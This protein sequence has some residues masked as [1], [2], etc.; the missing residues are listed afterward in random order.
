MHKIRITGKIYADANQNDWLPALSIYVY[1]CKVNSNRRIYFSPKK[2]IHSIKDLSKKIG[3]GFTTLNQHI[4]TLKVKGLVTFESD[5]IAFKT[6]SQ[7]IGISDKVLFI[8]ETVKSYSDV[9]MF[10][11]AIPFI[12][13]LYQQK[14]TISKKKHLAYIQHKVTNNLWLSPA[15]FKQYK[16]WLSN[17]KCNSS[18]KVLNEKIY[19]TINKVCDLI[20][21]KSAT[22]AVKYKKFL[23]RVGVFSIKN[24]VTHIFD[25][26]SW[27]DYLNLKRFG[28]INLKFTFFK[29]GCVWKYNP[30]EY[31]IT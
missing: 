4:N 11:N 12:S 5:H 17:N 1:F 3:V 21:K 28:E 2:R 22:T 29:F 18:K 15:E 14:R 30:T 6:T 7:I 23:E 9:K 8:P 10:L 24:S 25:N 27:S 31:I 26:V 13:R 16:K 19:A 20:D